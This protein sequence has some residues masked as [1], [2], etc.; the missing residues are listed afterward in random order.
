MD[1]DTIKRDVGQR[2]RQLRLQRGLTAEKLADMAD[3][4]TQALSDIELGKRLAKTETII[5]L[6]QA[7]G[8]SADYILGLEEYSPAKSV[9]ALMEGFEE[10]ETELIESF[11]QK[12]KETYHP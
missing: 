7:L 11:I 10:N 1:R 8:T 2:V 12:L 5:S 4:T 6:C 9:T 3:V